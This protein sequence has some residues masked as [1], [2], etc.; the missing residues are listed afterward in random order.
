MTVEESERRE[1]IEKRQALF[2]RINSRPPHKA[3]ENFPS[4]VNLIR[5]DR[6]SR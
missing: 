1:R 6:D 3:P 2:E 4:T 5:E